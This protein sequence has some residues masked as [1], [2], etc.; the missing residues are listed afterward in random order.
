VGLFVDPG[1]LGLAL[2]LQRLRWQAR[3]WLAGIAFSFLMKSLRAQWVGINAEVHW[4][5]S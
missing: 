2:G 5:S 4:R 3:F 1:V